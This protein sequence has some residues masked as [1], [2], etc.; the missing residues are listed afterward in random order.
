MATPTYSGDG[1]PTGDNGGGWFG[2]L[3][4]FFGGG[5][6]AYQP[7]PAPKPSELGEI[8]PTEAAKAVSTCGPIAIIVPRQGCVTDPSE[9]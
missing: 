6:P 4:S 5:T 7:A 9:P 1:Q 3:G 2:R 8:D